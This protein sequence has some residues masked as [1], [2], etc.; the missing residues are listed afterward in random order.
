M[1]LP[2]GAFVPVA[3]MNNF[4]AVFNG[5]ADTFIGTSFTTFGPPNALGLPKFT[6]TETILGGA[7][8]FA[9]ASGFFT[10]SGVSIRPSGPPTP[11]Q[12]TLLSSAGSGQITA[13]GLNP[14]PEPATVALLGAGL[15]GVAVLRRK[16]LS[17]QE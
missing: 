9:G 16:R 2:S 10:G 1:A 5:G 15:A 12:V 14:A 13:P 6:N 11:G 8:I 4:S 17:A 3:V 7:G